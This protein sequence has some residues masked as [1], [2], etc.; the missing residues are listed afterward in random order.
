MENIEAKKIFEIAKNYRLNKQIKEG[1][2]IAI[3]SKYLA[4]AFRKS[5][6]IG[7]LNSRDPKFEYN[8]IQ[9]PNKFNILD[10]EFSPLDDNLLSV[11]YENKNFFSLIKFETFEKKSNISN[12]KDLEHKGKVIIK[13]FNQKNANIICS[14]TEDGM[15]YF[16]NIGDINNPKLSNIFKGG[17]E[18]KGISW[19]PNGN[20]VGICFKKQS[21]KIFEE[22][23]IIFEQKISEEEIILKNFEWIDEKNIITIGWENNEQKLKIWDVNNK[24]YFLEEVYFKNE[25]EQNDIVPFVNREKKLIYIVRKE[26]NITS[27]DSIILYYWNN[28]SKLQKIYEYSSPYPAFFTILLND[29]SY[30]KDSNEID[31]FVQFSSRENKIYYVSFH[32]QIN[33]KNTGSVKSNSIPD[34]EK[35]KDNKN[36]NNNNSNNNQKYKESNKLQNCLKKYE[37]YPNICNENLLKINMLKCELEK[38]I[39][40]IEEI[41]N[42]N[43]YLKKDNDNLINEIKI[44]QDIIDMQN[45]QLINEENDIEKIINEKEMLTEKF[46]KEKYERDLILYN[47]LKEIKDL[48]IQI[49]KL[50]KEKFERDLILYNKSI[51]IKELNIQI[52]NLDKE[53]YKRDLI[54]YNKSTEIKNLNKQINNFKSNFENIQ[55]DKEILQINLNIT[56]KKLEDINNK[57]INERKKSEEKYKEYNELTNKYQKLLISNHIN[58]NINEII[59]QN[60]FNIINNNVSINNLNNNIF[61]ENQEYYSGPFCKCVSPEKN[62]KKYA[63]IGTKKETFSIILRNIGKAKWNRDTK[64]IKD[65]SSNFQIDD[66]KLESHNPN[67]ENIYEINLNQIQNYPPGEYKIVLSPKSEDNIIGKPIILVL[68]IYDSNIINKFRKEFNLKEQDYDDIKIYNALKE[69]YYIFENAFK[70]FFP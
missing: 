68:I 44:K 32:F 10:I 40:L 70:S 26:E 25:R 23:K 22:N 4:M 3:N 31:R 64:L 20:L 11:S 50:E 69:N 13:N 28:E 15:I 61:I 56:E 49:E 46:E 58:N 41:Q 59:Q 51:E 63:K 38:Q 17:K 5:G 42:K 21:F 37:N 48:T 1:R 27:K 62:L 19:N 60:G 45:N 9:H 52:E 43:K 7:L 2:Q 54:I 12:R 65:K 36:K 14:C 6:E 66:I 67:E 35:I 39:K 8:S 29:E 33:T 30:I 16:W 34:G 47:R 55:K 57:L 24:Q 18:P 53:K